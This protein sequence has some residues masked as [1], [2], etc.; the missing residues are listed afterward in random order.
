MH[1]FKEG[2]LLTD[3]KFDFAYASGLFDSS[4][5]FV[6]GNL[7]LLK[8]MG[9]EG[10]CTIY[11]V[12][13]EEGQRKFSEAAAYCRQH[14]NELRDECVHI[15]ADGKP[16]CFMLSMKLADD[17]ENF[18]VSLINVTNAESDTN[19][20]KKRLDNARSYISLT[21][22]ALFDYC[23]ATDRFRLY[24]IVNCQDIMLY[25]TTFSK[26]VAQ[27]KEQNRITEN[28]MEAFDA[29]CASLK[30][31]EV[32]QSHTFHGCIIT[33]AN[34]LERYRVNFERKKYADSED[35]VLGTWAI[36][37]ESSGDSISDVLDDAHI[38]SLTGL[39]N[40]KTVIEYAHNAL[41]SENREHVAL[42]I[43]DIDDFKSIND[44]YGHMFGD[45][46]IK[47]VA[48]VIQNAAGTDAAA[49]RIGGDEFFLV[50]DKFSEELEFRQVLR[51][52]KTNVATLF[53]DQLGDRRLSCSMGLAR[54]GFG[55]FSTTYHDLFKIAD[56]ALYL[57]KLKGKNRYIIYKPELH[58]DFNAQNE[59]DIINV[60]NSFY[61]ET[62]INVLHSM[63]SG[64]II[65]GTSEVAITE[66]LD[67]L[68][69]VLTLNRVSIFLNGADKPSFTN[70]MDSD[71]CQADS[72]VINN[73]SYLKLFVNNLL[74]VSDLHALEFATPDEYQLLSDTGITCLMQYTLRNSS[75]EIAGLI[76][77]DVFDR[78]AAFPKAS[79]TLFT[80][81]CRTM[82]SVFIR[83]KL[84]K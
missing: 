15:T 62:D 37:N 41:D 81:M 8:L 13:A 52:I 79:I 40:K 83:E 50:F 17:G 68:S 9:S 25:D 20:L 43:I 58:G 5:N 7:E 14:P 47:A 2:S 82:N 21:G 30:T 31:A 76:S 48:E 19:L 18:N 23:P 80:D 35:V 57:A 78:Y 74:A 26:W 38:D 29:F 77:A 49:G 71:V 65:N 56:R 69:K 63:L 22:E 46:V 66:I 60:S 1:Y 11:K 28:D 3:T 6:S 44:N 16:C 4:L 42:A 67:Y 53:T 36:I 64:L 70:T 59:D 55:P 27:M 61:S 75:G 73:P 33:D 84:L 72:S 45:K 54:Y 51:C 10:K 32:K 24:Y 12:L 39:L 34:Q